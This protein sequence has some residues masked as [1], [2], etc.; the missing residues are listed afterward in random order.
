LKKFIIL[1][2]TVA[3]LLLLAVPSSFSFANPSPPI[4]V[5]FPTPV[6]SL[7]ESIPIKIKIPN[8]QGFGFPRVPVE[9]SVALA[10][11]RNQKVIVPLLEE[12]DLTNPPALKEFLDNPIEKLVEF[13]LPVSKT[14]TYHIVTDIKCLYGPDYRWSYWYSYT[15]NSLLEIVSEKMHIVGGIDNLLF[16]YSLSQSVVYDFLGKGYSFRIQVEVVTPTEGEVLYVEP[17]AVFGTF[18]DSPIQSQ[19]EKEM[20]DVY[21]KYKFILEQ[22]FPG[23]I[24]AI[25]FVH[26]G[27]GDWRWLFSTQPMSWVEK[28]GIVI[29]TNDPH[30]SWNPYG[31]FQLEYIGD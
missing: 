18:F 15:S 11:F 14:G 27:I 13:P 10:E 31:E 4:I 25:S 1:F 30:W 17:A 24:L 12:V 2:L 20:E 23:S 28:N 19:I 8:P 7:V 6:G 3:V 26:T 16:G 21:S 9:I 29:A 22:Q 5:E